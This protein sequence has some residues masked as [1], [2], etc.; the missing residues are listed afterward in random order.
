MPISLSHMKN[1]KR[2]LTVHYFG[3]ECNVTYRPSA[4]TPVTE[5]AL[6]DAEDNTTLIDTL[7]EMIVAWDVLDEEG[8]PLP[9][10][11]DVLNQLPNA[12][13][14]HVLQACR[15]DMLPKSRNGRR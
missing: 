9:I 13:L 7:A 12:F 4:L 5:N 3:D 15:E 11:A 6:R 8:K 1:D 10:E 2:T 14:G